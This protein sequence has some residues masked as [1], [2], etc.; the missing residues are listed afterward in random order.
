MR[1]KVKFLREQNA[2]EPVIEVFRFGLILRFDHHITN[3][4][5]SG[6]I[7]MFINVSD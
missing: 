4:A 3:A 7:V 2:R 6:S 5:N 1:P